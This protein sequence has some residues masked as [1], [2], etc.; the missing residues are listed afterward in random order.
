MVTFISALVGFVLGTV[1][2][3]ILTIGNCSGGDTDMSDA[4][5]A[6]RL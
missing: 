1:A 6:V 5:E 3:V 2:G 4:G